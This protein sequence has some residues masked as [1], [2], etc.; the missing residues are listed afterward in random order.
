MIEKVL[1]RRSLTILLLLFICL[2]VAAVIPSPNASAQRK[3]TQR[4]RSPKTPPKPKIDYANFSHTT[5]AVTQKLACDS[6]HKV[7][8]KNWN[9]VR[10]GDAAFQD[11]TD[12]P[13]HSSCLGCHRAQFFAR[14]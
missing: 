8:S 13:E 4:S 11:V 12:F 6:C 3:R 9:V 7:P 2:G 5:H 14:E 10:K 1:S